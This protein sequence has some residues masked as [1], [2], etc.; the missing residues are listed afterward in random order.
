MG[1][2]FVSTL[3]GAVVPRC[4]FGQIFRQTGE[5]EEADWLVVDAVVIAAVAILA[6]RNTDRTKPAG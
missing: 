4:L 6:V 3:A 1:P 5:Y 2:S